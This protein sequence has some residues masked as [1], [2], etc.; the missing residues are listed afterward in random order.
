MV[1]ELIVFAAPPADAERD[2]QPPMH[3][4]DRQV[5]HPQV[6]NIRHGGFGACAIFFLHKP[7]FFFLTYSLH[8]AS[9]SRHGRTPGPASAVYSLIKY[10]DFDQMTAARRGGTGPPPVRPPRLGSAT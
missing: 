7:L 2:H 3:Q 1:F 5:P 10:R 8:R 4:P 9:P 6:G